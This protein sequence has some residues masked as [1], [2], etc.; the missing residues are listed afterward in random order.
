[1]NTVKMTLSEIELLSRKVFISNGCDE[2]NTLALVRTIVSAERDGALSHGLFRIPGYIAALR[3]GK[4]NGKAKP[5]VCKKTPVVINIDGA[6]GFAPLALE[7]AIDEI[8][9]AVN[10]FG[11]AVLALTKSHHFA[12]LW[13][14]TEALANKGYVALACVNSIACVAPFGGDEPIFGTNPLS[15]AWPRKNKSPMVIDMATS[16][17]AMGEV[18]IAARESLQVPMGTGLDSN[19][20]FSADPAEIIK[21]ML[22][23]FGGHKGSAMAMM[24]E[25]LSSAAIGECFSYQAKEND[26]YDGGPAQGG[27]FLIAFD[28]EVL[29]GNDWQTRSEAFFKRFESIKGCRL[30]GTNRHKKRKSKSDIREVNQD[31]FNEINTLCN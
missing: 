21:G 3:S 17:M 9:Q 1:M 14:E 10:N 4:V 7:F 15:F 25:L 28:P 13:P 5:I 26:N 18:Q 30:P 24:V 8:A 29:S 12:A 16:T 27:Q 6:N 19:G 22:L 2:E 20:D 11:I 23:P 31:L